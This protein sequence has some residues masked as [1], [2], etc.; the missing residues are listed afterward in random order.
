MFNRAFNQRAN[1]RQD[2]VRDIQKL[3]KFY[4]DFL[5]L[6]LFHEKLNSLGSLSSDQIIDLSNERM[7]LI[8]HLG[9]NNPVLNASPNGHL[10][11]QEKAAI[12]ACLNTI[13]KMLDP[14]QRPEQKDPKFQAAQL[15]LQ[16]T[17]IDLAR[18]RVV[19]QGTAA[20]QK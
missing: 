16:R 17:G 7:R 15:R 4:L 8:N 12:Q 18:A 14:S 3:Q 19:C 9:N 11:P 13:E 20:P 5:G 2:I 6:R 1:V 10:D